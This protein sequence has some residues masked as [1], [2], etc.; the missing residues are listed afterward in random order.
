MGTE[1][2][3]R[4]VDVAR[5]EGVATLWADMRGDNEGKR[6]AAEKVGFAL[7][8]GPTDEVIRAEMRLA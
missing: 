2:L 6:R 5:A 4:I 3:R 1:L 7:G 8:P